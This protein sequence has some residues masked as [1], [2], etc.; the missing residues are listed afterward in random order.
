MFPCHP[1]QARMAACGTGLLLRGGTSG[2]MLSSSTGPSPSKG[3]IREQTEPS[4]PQKPMWEQIQGTYCSQRDVNRLLAKQ[5]CPK[6]SW[7][8]KPCSGDGDCSLPLK[9]SDKGVRTGP[10]WYLGG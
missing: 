1:F 8:P 6:T 7:V 2:Q 4:S 9:D 5:L 3:A 10:S